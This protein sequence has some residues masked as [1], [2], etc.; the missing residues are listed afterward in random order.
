MFYLLKKKGS[1]KAYISSKIYKT[2]M[3]KFCRT[4]NLRG[5]IHR[6][7]KKNLVR[8]SILMSKDIFSLSSEICVNLLKLKNKNFY[9]LLMNKNKIQLKANTKWARD[10]QL[11]H[12]PLESYFGNIKSICKDNKLREFYFKFLH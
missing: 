9:K 12:I 6:K 4:Q 8:K 10:V 11:D 3:A 7:C 1:V 2:Q 5:N